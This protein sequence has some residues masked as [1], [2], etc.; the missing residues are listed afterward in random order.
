MYVGLYSVLVAVYVFFGRFSY[1]GLPHVLFCLRLSFIIS[2]VSIT[3]VISILNRVLLV[4]L[5]FLLYFAIIFVSNS[6]TASTS[7][8]AAFFTIIISCTLNYPDKKD[9]LFWPQST[10]ICSKLSKLLPPRYLENFGGRLE[11]LETNME[12]MINIMR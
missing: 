9:T 6:L 12:F 1:L 3:T 4:S 10:I 7:V 8:A 5:L 2:V 11:K